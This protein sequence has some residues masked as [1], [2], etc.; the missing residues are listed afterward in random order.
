MTREV[1]KDFRLWVTVS[2]QDRHAIP[3]LIFLKF[4]LSNSPLLDWP[5]AIV[6]SHLLS[7]KKYRVAEFEKQDVYELDVM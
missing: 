1:H 3:G 2:A 4:R 5:R 6:L 7:P